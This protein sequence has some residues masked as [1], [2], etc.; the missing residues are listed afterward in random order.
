MGTG[1]KEQGTV[2]RGHWPEDSGQETVTVTGAGN[3]IRHDVQQL[4]VD[5]R[6]GQID[7]Q[8]E[9][10]EARYSKHVLVNTSV[11]CQAFETSQEVWPVVFTK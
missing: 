10:V 9:Q 11:R 7:S 2:D 1:N 5:R 4:A 3:T 8:W 6:H